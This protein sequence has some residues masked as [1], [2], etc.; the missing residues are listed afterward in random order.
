MPSSVFFR[1]INIHSFIQTHQKNRLHGT[2]RH[3]K[4]RDKDILVSCVF[5]SGGH[6]PLDT[7]FGRG[8]H[9]T[10]DKEG[11]DRGRKMERDHRI[12]DR[13]ANTT[14]C[15]RTGRRET[16]EETENRRILHGQGHR[17]AWSCEQ[18][19]I[20]K[21]TTKGPEEGTQQTCIEHILCRSCVE[22]GG[23]HARIKWT[24]KKR[25]THTT[26]AATTV[27]QEGASAT[28]THKYWDNA[29]KAWKLG[30]LKHDWVTIECAV[31][32]TMYPDGNLPTDTPPQPTILQCVVDT[33]T[34]ITAI[35]RPLAEKMGIN[36]DKLSTTSTRIS[37]LSGDE[38]YPLG[39]FYATLTGTRKL[40]DRNEEISTKEIVYVFENTPNPYLSRVPAG[41]GFGARGLGAGLARGKTKVKDKDKVQVAFGGPGYSWG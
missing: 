22:K 26:A 38:I 11:R 5:G 1:S 17:W 6:H 25:H 9:P 10:L 40:K 12:L 34:M 35:G 20:R 29:E 39:S 21:T 37:S 30:S 27:L 28:I 19:A 8:K 13:Q 31:D 18:P 15:R 4:H 41:G 23:Q 36:C 14:D 2:T 7:S 3:A 32:P 24:T 16:K 33:G